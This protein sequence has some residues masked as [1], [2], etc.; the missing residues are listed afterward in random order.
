MIL[1]SVVI[2][3]MP[4][5]LPLARQ[6]AVTIQTPFGNLSWAEFLSALLLAIISESVLWQVRVHLAILL[7]KWMLAVSIWARLMS[8]SLNITKAF[9]LQHCHLPSLLLAS[10]LYRFVISSSPIFFHGL[11]SIPA[12]ISLSARFG[13][14][15]PGDQ[16]PGPCEQ[17]GHLEKLAHPFLIHSPSPLPLPAHY[18]QWIVLKAWN[19]SGKVTLFDSAVSLN[20]VSAFISKSK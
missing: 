17:Q 16:S 13:N 14:S 5:S 2:S 6:T 10:P 19:N 9:H 11:L 4:L 7:S 18:P 12:L 1:Y 3:S 15:Q 8:E 20:Y